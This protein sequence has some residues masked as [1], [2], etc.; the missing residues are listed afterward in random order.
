MRYGTTATKYVKQ[1]VGRPTGGVGDWPAEDAIAAALSVVESARLALKR[2]KQLQPEAV[3]AASAMTFQDADLLTLTQQL[4]AVIDSIVADS[5][6]TGPD[7][8]TAIQAAIDG[9]D[10][11]LVALGIVVGA[12]QAKPRAAVSTQQ[13][14]QHRPARRHVAHLIHSIERAPSN[15]WTTKKGD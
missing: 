11:R 7:K 4:V 15:T 10:A 9:Y 1:L 6:M 2:S 8:A 14:K 12:E 5:V 3:R 13:A